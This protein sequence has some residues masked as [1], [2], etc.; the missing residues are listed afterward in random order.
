M[1]AYI[2]SRPGLGAA[3]VDTDKLPLVRLPPCSHV[4]NRGSLSRPLK[5]RAVAFEAIAPR[6]GLCSRRVPSTSLRMRQHIRSLALGLPQVRR[7]VDHRDELHRRVSV[8]SAELEAV[9]SDALAA[10]NEIEDAR[11]LLDEQQEQIAQLITRLPETDSSLA[12]PN[13]PI[14]LL[15]IGKTG[16]TTLTHRLAEVCGPN[17]LL[18]AS[19]GTQDGFGYMRRGDVERQL[20]T[21]PNDALER[22]R[23]L[24]GHLPFGF[25]APLGIKFSY[26]SFFRSPVERVLSGFLYGGRDQLKPD[27][28]WLKFALHL[29]V[30]NG[31][32][33][34]DNVVTR[35]LTGSE[36]LIP[37]S[38][39]ATIWE[40]PRVTTAD[41][42]LAID[43]LKRRFGFV[44]LTERFEDSCQML[45]AVLRKPYHR[46]DLRLNETAL[47]F[48]LS[49]VP[50]GTMQLLERHLAHDIAVYAAACDRFNEFASAHRF[51]LAEPYARRTPEAGAFSSGDHAHLVDAQSTFGT[52]PDD[53]WLS[54]PF[55][56]NKT[57]EFI[58]YHFAES[59]C[60]RSVVIQALPTEPL[61]EL[62]FLIEASDDDFDRDVRCVHQIA[63]TADRE[64]R[65]FE[66]PVHNVAARSWRLRRLDGQSAQSL[67]IC[68]L[69]FGADDG[70]PR[71]LEAAAKKVAAV[72]QRFRYQ[73]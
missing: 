50:S 9:R 34:F 14:A 64:R 61:Q 27:K 45:F 41:R 39:K 59:Y 44:G 1:S 48:D 16:G 35:L 43:R 24:C 57:G 12:D 23:I 40:L 72:K 62:V 8:L 33:G 70:A 66:L 3:L 10:R 21:L 20:R 29:S 30:S 22:L 73:T 25:D 28:E 49:D 19:A 4:G 56:R 11:R 7:L 58:G 37:S 53:V 69:R 36:A 17:E 52:A 55:Y 54:C 63:L 2:T 6:G 32:A 42:A 51:P 15:H 38:P 71:D 65:H 31:G 67:I 68:Y 18:I 47:D 26:V 60:C 46:S 13:T 5:L